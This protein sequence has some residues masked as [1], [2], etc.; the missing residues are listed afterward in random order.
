MADPLSPKPCHLLGIP[1]E[2]RL[3]IY[4]SFLSTCEMRDKNELPLLHTCKFL[5]HEALPMFLAEA[6]RVSKELK[7]TVEELE[8]QLREKERKIATLRLRLALRNHAAMAH[9]L[10]STVSQGTTVGA[11][12]NGT[13]ANQ[14]EAGSET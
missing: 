13:A 5:R 3:E 4:E 1:A 8:A 12:P 9:V 2:L 7:D 11:A 14:E 10:V 6:K